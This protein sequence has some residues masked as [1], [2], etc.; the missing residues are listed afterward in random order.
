MEFLIALTGPSGKRGRAGG[1]SGPEGK[2]V[3]DSARC[4]G[5]PEA[6]GRNVVP[7]SGCGIPVE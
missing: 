2:A 3:K 1:F 5:E 6:R 4:A 7:V